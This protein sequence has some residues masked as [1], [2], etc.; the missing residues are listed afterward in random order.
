MCTDEAVWRALAIR[1]GYCQ[2][3]RVDQ[4]RP[5]GIRVVASVLQQFDSSAEVQANQ[6]LLDAT[7]ERYRS[8]NLTDFFDQCDS[9]RSLCCQLWR[10]GCNWSGRDTRGYINKAPPVIQPPYDR[11]AALHPK[12]PFM[13]H[14]LPALLPDVRVLHDGPVGGGAWRCKL[15]P[16]EKT[17]IVTGQLGGIQVFDH[18]TKTLLWHIAK[19]ATRPCPHLEF[20]RGWM[21][22]DRP[23]IGHFE[24]W[25]SE[26]L[27]PDL[28]RAPDRGH[29]QRFTVLS[30]VRPIRAY[31]FQFPYL[32]AASQDGFIM[33]WN[34]PQKEVVETID[35]R[36]SAHREGNINYIDFDDEYVFLV[37]NGAKS[38]SAFS[39]HNGEMVWN[40]GQ[41]FASG[42][43]PPTTWRLE[44]DA[45]QFFSNRAY[46]ARKL[47]RAQPNLWQ[48]GPNTMNFAQ[49]T[50]TPYQMWSAVHPDPNT[51]TLLILGHGTVLLIRDYKKFFSEPSQEPEL[52]IEIEFEN[53]EEYYHRVVLDQG[54]DFSGLGWNNRQ[55]WEFVGDAMMTVHEGR[56]VIVNETTLILDLNIDSA[57]LHANDYTTDIP[58]TL[59]DE[60]MWGLAD[61]EVEAQESATQTSPT[62]ADDEPT[63]EASTNPPSVESDRNSDSSAQCLPP[64]AVFT[65]TDDNPGGPHPITSCSS[66]QMDE[67]GVYLAYNRFDIPAGHHDQDEDA[68]PPMEQE[69]RV[70]EHLDFSKRQQPVL[71]T[72]RFTAKA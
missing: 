40:M 12:Y 57:M 15:D 50:M 23:G 43:P 42:R 8:R 37:G 62:I 20:S 22:F 58:F 2:L 71:D 61:W 49:L 53:L 3:A 17:F 19:T 41:H 6:S 67:V 69:H 64:V 60:V 13:P 55:L 28:G 56:A 30:S 47:V 46:V 31:R 35:F 24:V 66:V 14:S 9:W 25:R 16:E 63:Q 32:C 29:Y 5:S 36:Q 10:L 45:D 21:I 7:L 54:E 70:L 27:V 51:K 1:M 68:E 34:V 4:E 72:Y 48:A 33:I 11:E 44:E 26:R 52:F 59:V 18:A 39:R 38:M 65:Y